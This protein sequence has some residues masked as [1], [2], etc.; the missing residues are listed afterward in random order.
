MLRTQE[1]LEQVARRSERYY[2]ASV[3]H[4]LT[5]AHKRRFVA[6]DAN[7]GAWSISDGWEAVDELRARIPDADVHT[8][9]HKIMWTASIGWVPPGP[10][11]FNQS[12]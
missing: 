12:D 9:R 2:H 8:I 7:S 3:K 6:I 5:D 1:E 4:Q 10:S 11:H